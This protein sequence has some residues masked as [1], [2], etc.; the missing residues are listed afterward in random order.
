M[1]QSTLLLVLLSTLHTCAIHGIES[2]MN[3]Y[4]TGKI[5]TRISKEERSWLNLALEGLYKKGNRK[6]D[7]L[8]SFRARFIEHQIYAK[9]MRHEM[10]S[11]EYKACEDRK[12]REISKLL[13]HG[14]IT[15]DD[16]LLK[17]L[18]RSS[19]ARVLLGYEM[20]LY[21]LVHCDP[22]TLSTLS[23]WLIDQ[24][25]YE[26]FSLLLE[27]L[28][29]EYAWDQGS[30]EAIKTMVKNALAH[31]D[32]KL[33]DTFAELGENHWR[34]LYH[35]LDA[36]NN[37]DFFTFYGKAKL[38]DMPFSEKK[39]HFKKLLETFVRTEYNRIKADFGQRSKANRMEIAK[40]LPITGDLFN[41]HIENYSTKINVSN[42]E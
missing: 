1:K 6:Q 18:K 23:S 19:Y 11:E 24:K 32:D 22:Y 9:I 17:G 28:L 5:N 7:L 10:G 35:A 15:K 21:K 26:D 39:T 40:Y 37:D 14:V 42:Q 36:K 30:K 31:Q 34:T 29:D 3:T 38:K 27:H 20:P 4:S 13:I 41:A 2:T 16:K 33:T 25:Q 12:V 8:G